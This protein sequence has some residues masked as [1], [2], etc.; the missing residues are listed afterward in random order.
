V[1]AYD[2]ILYKKVLESSHFNIMHICDY[3]GTYIDFEQK[4]RDYPGHVVNVPLSADN[5][6][7]TMKEASA[8]FN[9][10]VMGGLDRHGIFSTGSA[11]DA[12]KAAK[13]VLK[14]APDNFILG[15]DCTVSN[16]IPM[17]NLQA[18]IKA[19]HEFKS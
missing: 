9:R 10:P 3:E 19:A 4:F 5:K 7:L 6:P 14:S 11:D 13:D 15:A 1:K 2:M 12:S 18:A 16:K 8:I 17:A